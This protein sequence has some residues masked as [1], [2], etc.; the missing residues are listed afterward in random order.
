MY[1][2][3]TLARYGI[4]RW[5]VRF[6]LLPGPV[7]Q[8]LTKLTPAARRPYRA[9]LSRPAIIETII[10]EMEAMPESYEQ[11]RQIGTAAGSL[12]DLPLALIKHGNHLERLPRNPAVELVSRYDE[13]Y[14]DVQNELACLSSNH[15]ILTAGSSGHSIQIDQPEMVVQAVRWVLENGDLP[16]RKDAE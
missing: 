8:I 12:G 3:H 13:A 1:V 6:N 2:M 4:L 5:I 11:A 9:F 10:K 14:H 16:E 15:L 7:K